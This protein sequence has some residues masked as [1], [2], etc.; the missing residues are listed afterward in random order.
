MEAQKEL[1]ELQDQLDQAEKDLI[2]AQ[3]QDDSEICLVV[4]WLCFNVPQVGG[5]GI[6]LFIMGGIISILIVCCCQRWC[7]GTCSCCAPGE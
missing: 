5:L 4:Y 3:K 2:E 1:N 6:T 7:L